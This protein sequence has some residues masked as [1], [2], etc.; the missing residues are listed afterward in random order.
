MP[1]N[2]GFELNLYSNNRYSFCYPSS[3]Y[4]EVVEAEFSRYEGSSVFT[5]RKLVSRAQGG[6]D[7]LPNENGKCCKSEKNVTTN[8]RSKTVLSAWRHVPNGD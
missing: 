4:E 1:S 8:S 3:E 6:E 2:T 7:V 5:A